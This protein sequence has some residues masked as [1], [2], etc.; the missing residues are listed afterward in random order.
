MHQYIHF[1]AL[2]VGN[3]LITNQTEGF[4]HKP[5]NELIA[6]ASCCQIV[7]NVNIINQ[8]ET[9][10]ALHK[11]LNIEDGKTISSKHSR[12]QYEYPNFEFSIDKINNC[13]SHPD[14]IRWLKDLHINYQSIF[15]HQEFSP[16]QA[17]GSEI[18]FE[19]KSN[20]TV[21]HQ[22]YAKINP[23]ILQKAQEIISHLLQQ[24][25]IDFSK[26]PWNSRVI[27]VKKAADE[28]QNDDVS[29]IPGQKKSD[30][31]FKLRL[32]LDLRDINKRLKS[33]EHINAPT[34]WSILERLHEASYVSLLDFN[35]GFWHF[36]LAKNCRK[37]TAFQF[38]D[39]KYECTR[40]PQGLKLSSSIMQAKMIAFVHRH[41]LNGIFVYIDN[42]LC[43]GNTKEIY[44]TNLQNLFKALKA[45]NFKLK[46]SKSH[47][48]IQD[49]LILFGFQ[50][51]LKRKN[52]RP[53]PDKISKIIDLPT[54]KTKK[55]LRQFIGAVSYFSNF[56]P[57]LQKHM[58]PLHDNTAK[59]KTFVW[60][61]ECDEKF[62]FIKKMLQA[63]PLLFLFNP[64]K[65]VH[66]VTD[67]AATSHIA[68]T[69]YQ[70]DQNGSFVPIKFNSH[71]L[72]I[73]EARLSQYETELLGLVFALIKEEPFLA[74]NNGTLHTDAK[75]LCFLAKFANST[76]K[77]YR[78]SIFLHSYDITV[79]FLP[80]HDA[81]IKFSDLLTRQGNNFKFSNKISENQLKDFSPINLHGLNNMQITDAIH[82]ITKLYSTF[83]NDKS[84]TF[85]TIKNIFP[86][87]PTRSQLVHNHFVCTPEKCYVA[88]V[89][90]PVAP[91]TPSATLPAGPIDLSCQTKLSHKIIESLE[92]FLPSTSREKLVALQKTEQWLIKIIH[93]LK[94][95]RK[96]QNF[97][98][99][100]DIVCKQVFI[101]KTTLNLIVLPDELAK[102]LLT[103]LHHVSLMHYGVQK[104][105]Q[106]TKT[107][108]HIRKLRHICENIIKNCKFCML[109]KVYPHKQLGPGQKIFISKPRQFLYIDICSVDSSISTGN[110]LTVV[111]GFSKFCMFLPIKL[112]PTATEVCD[113]LL[114]NVI[115]PY[116]F[117]VAI[118]GDGAK[119][120]SNSLLGSVAS[121]LNCRYV[122]IV[123]YN[124]QANLAERFNKLALGALKILHQSY[125]LNQTNFNI[126]LII[127][128][129]MIN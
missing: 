62:L 50:I 81:R 76:S 37:Y 63:L 7:T 87:I 25:L 113:I 6:F 96:F 88:R 75:S 128:S 61:P 47:H 57:E 80:N 70:I 17:A 95:K 103:N 120:F 10:A 24:G 15:S 41:K 94:S 12:I 97:I 90:D 67:G 99:H 16:G 119:Y 33:V 77:L 86:D 21:I 30:T 58:A 105:I 42:L 106:A 9:C 101:N 1:D 84:Q 102:L 40:L 85:K 18:N 49:S 4:L 2:L 79:S 66:L 45:D 27:F 23:K 56:L 127:A 39:T 68:Y 91:I 13:S 100:D 109:N 107:V 121:I 72:S 92:N 74:Y 125:H 5:S 34:L 54:P 83:P 26:S 8:D 28:Y 118:S 3:I 51:D 124:S 38:L 123:A 122:K 29:H 104:M 55:E 11:L 89:V 112:N 108:F 73:T 44:K 116:G 43:Y 110:F 111:D 126:M 48:F 52:I 20:A 65:H 98:T 82:F 46:L 129:N 19:L 64:Q 93:E 71:R 36:N 31:N 115:R 59:N 32:V 114:N 117:P 60:T 78:W 14:D 69:M 53:E 22:K 35:S